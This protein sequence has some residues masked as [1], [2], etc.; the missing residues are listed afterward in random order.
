M[1]NAPYQR[2]FAEKHHSN[3]EVVPNYRQVIVKTLSFLRLQRIG[4][5]EAGAPFQPMI[6]RR[7]VTRKMRQWC[8]TLDDR[9]YWYFSVVL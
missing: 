7:S 5:S 4:Q 8:L 1:F 3:T 6:Y 9:A 2:L